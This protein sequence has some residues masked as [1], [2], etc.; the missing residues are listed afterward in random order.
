MPRYYFR[1]TGSLHTEIK[2]EG[3]ELPDKQAAWAEA[4]TACGELLRDID[5]ALKPGDTW[6]M[7]VT[8]EAG[9]DIYQLEFRTRE[10]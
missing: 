6:Q 7:M 4:T 2:R 3:L 8:D 1:I 10:L 5:G 9:R